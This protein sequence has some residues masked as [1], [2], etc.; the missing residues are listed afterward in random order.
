MFLQNLPSD[1]RAEILMAYL[2]GGSQGFKVVQKG[3]HKR[4]VYKDILDVVEDTDG[5]PL[6]DLG[7]SSLYNGLPEY[8]FHPIDRFNNLPQYE[9]KERFAQELEQQQKEKERAGRYFS[10]IDVGLMLLRMETTELIRP[11]TDANQLLFDILADRLNDEQRA[12]R[13]IRQAIP[14]LPCCKLIRGNRTLL[15]LLLRKVFLEEGLRIDVRERETECKDDLP[16]YDDRLDVALDDSFVGNVY[17]EMVR[18]YELHYWNNEACDEH[19]LSFVAD[20]EMFRQFIEDYF[21]AVEEVLRFDITNDEPT[22]RLTD[23]MVFNYL[24]YN[25]NI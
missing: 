6:L 21:L 10:P 23:D 24:D 3:L 17:D 12:N 4:N 9:E 16:R 13:F 15:T 20:L 2:L 1:L 19:F 8:M 14:F 7:R 11:F 5:T 18:T 25:T 22:L